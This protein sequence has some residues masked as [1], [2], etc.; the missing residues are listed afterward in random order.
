[1]KLKLILTFDHEL[2]L[3]GVRTSYKEALFDPT[4]RLFDLAG[5]LKVP[6]VL[7][8]DI[9]CAMRFK[10]WNRQDFYDPYVLQ[11]QEAVRKQHDVQLHLHP[12]WL[13]TKFLNNTFKPSTDYKLADFEKHNEWPVNRIIEEGTNLLTQI[14]IAADPNYKCN[15]FRAGGYNLEGNSSL[16]FS[17]LYQNGIRFDSSLIKGYYFRSGLSEI[18]YFNLPK[19]PNWFIGLTGDIRKPDINGIYE[20]PIASIPKTPFEVPTR[21]KLKKLANQGP[22]NHGY[23]IHEGNP[24][25]MQSKIKMMFSARM[26]SFDNYTLS[27]DYLMKNLSHNIRKYS[28]HDT[29]ILSISGHPKSMGDYS[30]GLMKDF[31]TRVRD[32]YPDTEFTTFTKLAKEMNF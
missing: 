20:I 18:N 19:Q 27:I 23:Q 15:S 21:F 11:L 29:A 26:L 31:V 10:E 8:S 6:V 5:E 7:F 25:D 32:K 13:T 14:C 24:T 9:L 1:M 17:T 30:F 28:K 16:I 22:K 2:P 4:Y 12:H 3:G